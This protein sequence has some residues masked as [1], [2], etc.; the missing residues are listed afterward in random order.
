MSSFTPAVQAAV[1]PTATTVEEQ[2]Q[3]THWPGTVNQSKTWGKC[4]DCHEVQ[5]F[6][7]AWNAETVCT[8]CD[9][10]M[11]EWV[12]YQ[13]YYCCFGPTESSFPGMT[14]MHCGELEEVIE[15]GLKEEEEQYEKRSALENL[16]LVD[17]VALRA[18]ADDGDL[19]QALALLKQGCDVD[20]NGP[21]GSGF[22]GM[23]PLCLSA[24]LGHFE[25]ARL[26]LDHGAGLEIAD[27]DGGTALMAAAQ[28]G[29]MP[30]VQLLVGRG[31]NCRTHED[32]SASVGTALISAATGGHLDVCRFLLASGAKA[33]DKNARGKTA[34]DE[35]RR[36]RVGEAKLYQLLTDAEQAE[37]GGS[38]E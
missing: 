33:G 35:A 20:D 28:N 15:Q 32:P 38:S 29:D 14:C 18:A 7:E 8:S 36:M 2:L 17:R 16:S 34:L 1:E 31:A 11:F 21:D 6:D 9:E 13:C 23:T 24:T 10:Q 3:P 27:N 25:L 30:L 5:P 12:C 26:F 19:A 4:K 37:G 22:E